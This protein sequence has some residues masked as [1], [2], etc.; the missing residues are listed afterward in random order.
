MKLYQL[1]YFLAVAR[2]KN[3]TR[4]AELCNVAQPSLT[5]AIKDLEYELHG[6]LFAREHRRNTLTPLGRFVRTYLD[7]IDGELAELRDAVQSWRN[8]RAPLRVGILS[9][10]ASPRIIALIGEF[11]AAHPQVDIELHDDDEARL[12]RGIEGG[13]LDL[14]FTVA[15]R[16]TNVRLRWQRLYREPY[17][18]AFAEGHRFTGYDRVRL[19]DLNEEPYLDQLTAD[20]RDELAL[21]CAHQGV[22]LKAA[23][24]SNRS[25]WILLAVATGIGV[26][27]LPRSSVG[28]GHVRTCP[29]VEPRIDREIGL[30]AA[31]NLE[32]SQAAQAFVLSASRHDWDLD[33]EVTS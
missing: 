31:P 33:E 22:A 19:A 20:V 24:R 23:C 10:I 8:L 27:I 30:I 5:R 11:S 17:V 12:E 2:T 25:E 14:A 13:K 1:K 32:Q 6:Q 16:R 26:A 9:G 4:A 29:L 18:V 3:F 15:H 7:R 28:L 21:A